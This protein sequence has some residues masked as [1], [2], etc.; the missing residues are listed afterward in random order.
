VEYA[1]HLII[2]IGIYLILA[3]GLNLVFG[4]GRLLN[5]AHVS[6]FAVGAYATA[7]LSV[8][9][10]WHLLAYLP[11]SALLAALL[12]LFTAAISMKLSTDYFAVGSLAFSALISAILINWK[13]LTRGVL[14]IPGIPRPELAGIDFYSNLNFA[15]LVW[16]IALF[17]SISAKFTW[18]SKL[19]RALRAYGE[20]SHAALS[21]GVGPFRV[22]TM[23]FM[24]AG[25]WAGLAGS[26]FATYMQYIDPSSFGLSEM[27]FVLTI[28]IVGKPG[29]F[30]GMFA[31]T[32]FM[33]LLPE[34][35]RQ[36]SIPPE[37]IGPLRQL[38]YAVLLFSVVFWKRKVLFPPE[39]TI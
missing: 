24:I 19:A 38:I 31:G 27:V 20:D 8:D 39:R 30:W 29:S 16:I 14:G 3:H 9:H 21:L 11:A 34:P 28:V 26:L 13:D 35:L 37:Y 10:A 7:L 4:L 32:A 1:L 23:A 36:I 15:C 12:A 6:L 17:V 5:L 25:A 18:R 22:R 33:I 2:L